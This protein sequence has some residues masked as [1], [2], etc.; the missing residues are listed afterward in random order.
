[1]SVRDAE[2]S[3]LAIKSVFPIMEAEP[4]FLLSVFLRQTVFR[5]FLDKE[6]F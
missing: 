2:R 6:V 4:V 1:M 5:A 3:A